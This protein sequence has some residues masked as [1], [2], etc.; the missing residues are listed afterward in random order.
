VTFEPP[1]YKTEEFHQSTQS[2][3]FGK[4]IYFFVTLSTSGET[5]MSFQS[6]KSQV[7]GSNIVIFPYLGAKG[8]ITLRPYSIAYDP[9]V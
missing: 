1:L 5:K 3:F 9:A 8:C 7:L 6:T 4:V 2:A